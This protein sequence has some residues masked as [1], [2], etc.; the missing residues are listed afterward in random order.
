[1]DGLTRVLVRVINIWSNPYDLLLTSPPEVPYSAALYVIKLGPPR[2]RFPIHQA[3]TVGR[4]IHT[5][6]QK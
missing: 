2:V 5:S 3:G 1:M 6:R 4:G